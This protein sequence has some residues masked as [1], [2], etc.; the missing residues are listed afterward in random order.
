MTLH[1]D[2]YAII[3]DIIGHSELLLS[4]AEGRLTDEQRGDIYT[5]LTDAEQFREIVANAQTH[6]LPSLSGD[7]STLL[8]N[9]DGFSELMLEFP[10]AYHNILLNETQHARIQAITENGRYLLHLLNEL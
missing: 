7:L 1:E 10:E 8:M 2:L 5:M 4:E 6:E 9:I 3:C